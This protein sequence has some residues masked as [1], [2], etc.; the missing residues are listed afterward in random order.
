MIYGQ[1]DLEITQCGNSENYVL[2]RFYR[3][4]MKAKFLMKK[5]LKS[6]CYQKKI[7]KFF[8]T[9]QRWAVAGA[10]GREV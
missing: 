4:F 7:S 9:V 2:L 3:E 10:D 8:H 1:R 5:L 6:R